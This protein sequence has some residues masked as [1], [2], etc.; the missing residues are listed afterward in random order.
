MAPTYHHGDLK[1]HLLQL[2]RDQVRIAGAEVL[3]L[4]ELSRQAGV[5]HAAAYRHFPDKEELLAALACEGFQSLAEACQCA[6]DKAGVD[7]A[8]ARLRGCGI[9]YI[10]FGV[11]EPQMLTLMWSGQLR[12]AESVPLQQAASAL[13]EML[14]D[15]AKPLLCDAELSPAEVRLRANACW[16]MV[17][18]YATLSSQGAMNHGGSAKRSKAAVRLGLDILI[19]GLKTK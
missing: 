2:A 5:S 4:R 7:K 12:F 1:A 6:M 18:G 13:F 19:A 10:E 11:T 14:V 15:A 17:H 3:S 8:E 16:A 9:A